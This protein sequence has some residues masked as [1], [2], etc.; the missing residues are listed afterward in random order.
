MRGDLDVDNG[1]DGRSFHE[2][3]DSEGSGGPRDD[4]VG[5]LRGQLVATRRYISKLVGASVSFVS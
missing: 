5:E 1:G 2:L 4:C 3:C